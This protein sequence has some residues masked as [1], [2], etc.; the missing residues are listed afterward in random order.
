MN[1]DWLRV[2]MQSHKD[3][4]RPRRGAYDPDPGDDKSAPLLAVANARLEAP[5]GGP[6]ATRCHAGAQSTQ[7]DKPLARQVGVP[8]R[9]GRTGLFGEC[10][11]ARGMGMEGAGPPQRAATSLVENGQGPKSDEARPQAQSPSPPQQATAAPNLQELGLFAA[12]EL[13]AAGAAWMICK[14]L[15]K[16]ELG[17]GEK[18]TNLELGVG[19]KLN[20]LEMNVK[21][22][23]INLRE[24]ITAAREQAARFEGATTATLQQHSALLQELLQIARD[25]K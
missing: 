8:R 24:E 6:R 15:D 5:D 10:A 9:G 2:Y 18:L 25:K 12:V 22:L 1:T 7:I 20:K 3:I 4:H 14:K 17:V 16:L 21:K 11:D 19:E 13:A 23:G